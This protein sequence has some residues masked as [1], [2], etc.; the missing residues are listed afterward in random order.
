MHKCIY[1]YINMS[2]RSKKIKNTLPEGGLSSFQ[3]IYITLFVIVLFFNPDK[4]HLLLK[5]I[6]LCNSPEG[7]GF[8]LLNILWKLKRCGQR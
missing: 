4:N 5:Y 2:L 1:A 8:T 6:L 7:E 3:K